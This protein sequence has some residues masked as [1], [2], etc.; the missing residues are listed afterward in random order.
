MNDKYKPC[1]KCGYGLIHGPFYDPMYTPPGVCGGYSREALVYRCA[2]CGYHWCEDVLDSQN[3]NE[4]KT[5]E[6]CK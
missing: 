2:Q 5:G 4:T 6:D 3:K 1:K